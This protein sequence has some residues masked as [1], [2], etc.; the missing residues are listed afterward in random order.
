LL[1]SEFDSQQRAVYKFLAD[2]AGST[3]DWDILIGL[4]EKNVDEEL[5]SVLL[6]KRTE[7]AKKS[8]E[9]L[10]HA[11]IKNLLRD[12]LSESN[13]E[14]N[15]AAQRTVL[16]KFART[17]LSSAQDALR[18][19]MKRASQAQTSDYASFHEVRK[20]GKKVRYL[21]EFFEPLL[22]KKQRRDL[23]DLKRLQ[24]RLDALNDVVAS[25][26]LLNS[27]VASLPQAVGAKPALRA[28]HKEQKKR[29]KA[30]AKHF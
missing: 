18:K 11:N 24:M 28:L 20:A 4:V 6:Q 26:D 1:D 8:S 22:R 7:A 16:K 25:R 29:V 23:K 14:L 27:H 12:A 2:A 15:T 19:R 3:R 10:S 21:L 17:R 30:A 9:T 13:R 5:L